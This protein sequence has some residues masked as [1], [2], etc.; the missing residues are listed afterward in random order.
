MLKL[1]I[2]Y[3][4][5]FFKINNPGNFLFSQA[6]THLVSLASK[7][8][9]AVFGMGTGVSSSLSS[10]EKLSYLCYLIYTILTLLSSTSHP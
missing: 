7:S 8:L 9:T 2:I 10:P 4:I 3:H 6:V 5:K 1:N